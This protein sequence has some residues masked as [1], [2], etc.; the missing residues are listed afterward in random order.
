MAYPKVKASE[1]PNYFNWGVTISAYQN[2]GKWNTYG[3]GKSI[4]DNFTNKSNFKNGNANVT[5]NF[6]HHY[7]EDIQKVKDLNLDSFRFSLSWSRIFPNGIGEI[8]Q[9]GVDFYHDIIDTCLELKIK[10]WVTLYHWDLP[11]ILEEKGGWN[12]RDVL[13]WFE[14]YVNFCTKEYGNKVKNWIVLNEPMSFVGLGYFM[15]MHAPGKKGMKNFLSAAHHTTLCQ[16]IGGRII[17]K[18]VNNAFIGTTFSCSYVKPMNRQV[19][20]KKAAERIDALLNRFFIEPAL[21]L[22]YPIDSIPGLKQIE[23]YYQ[24]G[25]EEMM[26]FDFD[27]IGIQYYFKIVAKFSLLPPILFATEIPAVKRNVKINNM[28]MEIYPKGI[29]KMLEKFNNYSNIKDLYITESGVCFD[30]IIDNGKI[31]DKKRIDYFKKTF[32]YT[33]K[34]IQKNIN[35]KG[36]FIWTLTDNFEWAEGTKPRFGL[37][38][39]DF[40]TQ[41]RTIKK[42]GIW[43]QKFLSKKHSF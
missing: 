43:I 23:K 33:L 28:G 27:F 39:T 20:N 11:Q 42:S 37:Y 5:T 36:Y 21:G 7:K 2:E 29:L 13:N 17:R 31:K 15:G 41:K 1:F 9:K 35:V 38:Y 3:K 19:K 14:N 30:D 40:V 24:P 18:N 8:N 12:N 10:P 16:A 6:Y 26:K 34:A 25:D 22:G 4:W 32:Y